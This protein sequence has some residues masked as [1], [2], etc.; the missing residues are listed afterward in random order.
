MVKNLKRFKKDCERDSSLAVSGKGFSDHEI[1]PHTFILPQDYS[2]FMDEFQK[3]PNKKWIV[4]PAARSQGKGIFI[5]SK[6]NQSKQLAAVLFKQDSLTKENFV[7]SKYIDNPLLIGGKKFDLRMY[8]LVTNYKPL[9][10]WKSNKAFARFCSEQYA[11]DDCDEDNLFSHLTNVSYQLKSAKYNSVHGGKWSYS[12]FL[13]YVEMNFGRKKYLKMVEEVDF[14][15]VNSLKAVQVES[16]Y[17][18]GPLQR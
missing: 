4:K 10:V 8:V 18:G 9:K 14:L 16:P 2:I 17:T 3:N 12:N 13:L 1:I 7:V 11:K 15:I 5:M 6:F